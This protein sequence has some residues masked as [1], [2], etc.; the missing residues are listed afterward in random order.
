MKRIALILITILASFAAGTA[1]AYTP[2]DCIGCHAEKSEESALHIP[3]GDFKASAHTKEE[4]SCPD[5]HTGVVDDSHEETVGSGAVDCVQC[6]EKE[7]RHA[8]QVLENRPKCYSCHTRH[9]ILAPEDE[10]SSV[11]PMQL[12]VTCRTCHPVE[13]R[14]TD[15]LSFLPSLQLS[16][17]KKQDFGRNYSRFNCIGCHQ[18]M[19]VH[20]EE[21]AISQQDCHKCHLSGQGTSLLMGYVHPK[22]DRHRQPGI[23]VAAV[24]YQVT[25]VM[26][27]VG[28]FGF[29][30][31][32]F[33]A[34]SKKRK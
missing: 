21:E 8:V 5:C 14:Q 10:I 33:A 29:F 25:V 31:R 6:H 30:V 2:E 28:G 26:M 13:C 19:A 34:K 20:G 7:N 11:N 27:L 17:H 4:L 32:L 18:G 24:I 1:G 22:A 16:S 12:K 23:F 9:R 15:Y 3:V